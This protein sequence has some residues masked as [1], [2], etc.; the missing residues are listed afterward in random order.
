MKNC[1]FRKINEETYV[2]YSNGKNG[3][4]KPE[5]DINIKNV[6]EN[7]GILYNKQKIEDKEVRSFSK[8]EL[9]KFE[10]ALKNAV[11]NYN[12]NTKFDMEKIYQYQ[13]MV[14]D[15]SYKCD[16]FKDMYKFE[17]EYPTNEGEK[18]KGRIDNVFV[19][20]DK[21]T[22]TGEVY[23]IELKVDEKVIGGTNGIHKHLID[24]EKIYNQ[25]R[26]EEFVN[27]LEERVNYRIKE[28]L[29]EDERVS[30]KPIQ[31]KRDI[32]HF[33]IVVAI[34]ENNGTYIDNAKKVLEM[35]KNL[36]DKEYIE[37]EKRKSKN[38]ALPKESKILSQHIET[39]NSKKCEI[40]ILYDLWEYNK[41]K[42]FN[43]S[44]NMFFT[45]LEDYIKNLENQ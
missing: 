33:W 38:I 31:L 25:N 11:D 22:N 23:L 17:M 36:E 27:T 24:I 35:M 1:L 40:K 28:L 10:N 14:R 9:E 4:A 30:F 12:K 29:H 44:K 43:I 3:L 32:L 26:L 45:N 16:E 5:V 20:I 41:E 37:T 6:L 15:I 19:K 8:N 42:N 2:A 34:S 39:L 21:N 7:N 13:V 18:D